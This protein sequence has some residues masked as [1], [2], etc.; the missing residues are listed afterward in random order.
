MRSFFPYRLID[1]LVL[2][3]VVAKPAIRAELLL[4]E[5]GLG[6]AIAGKMRVIEKH[7]GRPE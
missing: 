6:A 1:L 5:A 7:I 2:L 3:E 4:R